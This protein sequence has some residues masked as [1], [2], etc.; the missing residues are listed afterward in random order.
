MN[1]HT[2]MTLEQKA[3]KAQ[4]LDLVAAQA[5]KASDS[6]REAVRKAKPGAESRAALRAGYRANFEAKK[7]EREALLLRETDQQRQEREELE[8]LA[9]ELRRVCP[10]CRRGKEILLSQRNNR[11]IKAALKL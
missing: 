1:K 8:G 5:R 3:Q 7:A 4:E 11:L 10:H 2:D 6:Y 9:E